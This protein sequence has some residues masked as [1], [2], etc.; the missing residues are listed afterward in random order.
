MNTV[1]NVVPGDPSGRGPEVE[2]A[3]LAWIGNRGGGAGGSSYG[4]EPRG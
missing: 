3:T 2:R 1:E 4:G